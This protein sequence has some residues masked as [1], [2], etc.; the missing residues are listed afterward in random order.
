M[1]ID[2]HLLIS[3]ECSK[4]GT[5]MTT[6]VTGMNRKGEPINHLFVYERM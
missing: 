6:T 3:R 1:R 4:D 5:T 2:R